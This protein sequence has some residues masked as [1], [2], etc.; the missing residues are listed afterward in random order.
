MV[1]Y[2]VLR[3]PVISRLVFQ[4][5]VPLGTAQPRS[6]SLRRGPCASRKNVAIPYFR[7]NY[8]RQN[9]PNCQNTPGQQ[10]CSIQKQK[11]IVTASLFLIKQGKV[12]R[13]WNRDVDQ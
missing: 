3:S 10:R 4:A 2:S 6:E 9:R 11:I 8:A 5:S 12:S 1:P 7:Q 13:V